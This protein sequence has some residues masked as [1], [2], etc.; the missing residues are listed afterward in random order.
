VARV[1]LTGP[2]YKD[3]ER[4]SLDPGGRL[5][6]ESGDE[7]AR[8]RK[9]DDVLWLHEGDGLMSYR[10]TAEVGAWEAGSRFD[11]VYER[12]GYAGDQRITG[13]IPTPFEFTSNPAGQEVSRAEEIPVRWAPTDDRLA[14]HLRISVDD[15]WDDP[16]IGGYG[17]D[18]IDDDGEYLIPAGTLGID[19]EEGCPAFLRLYRCRA[20][21]PRPSMVEDPDWPAENSW[22][23]CQAREAEFVTTP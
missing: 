4:Y 8:M 6:L 9:V 13:T 10:Y 1:K 7:R 5:Y 21:E 20:G 23:L 19:P 15:D 3:P 11:I 2:G 12:E 22:T 16:C 17:E 18:G 14:E